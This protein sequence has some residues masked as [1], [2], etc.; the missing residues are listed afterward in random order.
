MYHHIL[1]PLDGSTLAEQ[2]IPHAR[3]LA[4][5]NPEA[6]LTVLR[7]VPPVLPVTT[8]YTVMLPSHSLEEVMDSDRAEAER[9][10]RHMA[11]G[12]QSQGVHVQ[13]E[14][15]WLPAAEAIVEYAEANKVDLIAIATHGRSGLSRW[16]F[17]SVTQKVL[18]GTRVP[19]LVI[20]PEEHSDA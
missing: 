12:L 11:S 13:V 1:V 17:G 7:A 4:T 20:R 16:V 3:T 2:V 15:S 9:Y 5:L 18:H 14:I 6:T 19:V 10:L 8:E